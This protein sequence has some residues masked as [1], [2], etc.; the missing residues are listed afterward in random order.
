MAQVFTAEEATEIILDDDDLDEPIMDGS[1]DDFSDFE[2][3]DENFT[4]NSTAT[5]LSSHAT[6][7]TADVTSGTEEHESINDTTTCTSTSLNSCS[8]LAST[9]SFASSTSSAIHQP[10]AFAVSL[11][12]STQTAGSVSN[13]LHSTSNTDTVLNPTP[14]QS[15]SQQDKRN[16]WSHQMKPRMHKLNNN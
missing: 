8:N 6:S 4:A 10:I 14:A 3:D 12:D 13:S 16:Q 5:E 2:W 15:N 9:S 7:S 1:D 11:L